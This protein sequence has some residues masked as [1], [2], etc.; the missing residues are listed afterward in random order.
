M[1]G[2][3]SNGEGTL[4]YDK[5]RDRWVVEVVTGRKSNGRPDRRRRTASTRKEAEKIRRDLVSAVEAGLAVPDGSRT[6]QGWLDYWFA[7][8]RPNEVSPETLN[9]DAY[10]ARLHLYPALGSRRLK[11]LQPEHVEKVLKAKAAAGYARSTVD[12]IKCVLRMGLAEAERRGEVSRNVATL[13]RTP[14]GAQKEGRALTVEQARSLLD[15]LEGHSRRALWLAVLLLGLRPGEVCGL[16]WDDID[17]DRE[18]LH[19]RRHRRGTGS[20]M[21]LGVPK[22]AKSR[23]SLD[24]PAPLVEALRSHKADQAR[25]RLAAGDAWQ[26]LGLVFPTES[27]RFIDG[28]NLRKELD[29]ITRRAGLGHWTPYELRHSCVSLLSAAG[30]PIEEVADLVGHADTTMTMTVYRHPVRPSVTAH[31]DTMARLVAGVEAL[32]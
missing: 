1:S 27:G 21:H 24:M 26:D 10:L 28:K 7:E 18:R 17:F 22:T 2:K 6:V 25:L 8:I 32:P 5:D 19:V 11:D 29:R 16:T 30:V 14:K 15:A 9:R 12:R 31:V 23:R 4:Y 13:V 20:D 3:R